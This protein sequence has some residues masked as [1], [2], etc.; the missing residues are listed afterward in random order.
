[1]TFHHWCEPLAL[2]AILPDNLYHKHVSLCS[3]HIHIWQYHLKNE[4]IKMTKTMS[5]VANTFLVCSSFSLP[6]WQSQVDNKYG[7]SSPAGPVIVWLSVS[8]PVG[9]LWCMDVFWSGRLP[10]VRWSSVVSSWARSGVWA[11][12]RRFRGGGL[13]VGV[14][15]ELLHGVCGLLDCFS[16]IWNTNTVW[17][18]LALLFYFV[19][20]KC[21]LDK[22]SI[23]VKKL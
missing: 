3:F 8:L 9:S 10:T 20:T 11:F 5:T 6:L 2:H 14:H 23:C 19:H 1:M 18:G 4:H 12:C 13:A 21:N 16:L 17:L 15:R 22:I 7:L